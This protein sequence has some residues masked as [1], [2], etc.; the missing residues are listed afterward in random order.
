MDTL[1]AI[2][3]NR[4]NEEALIGAVLIAPYDVY[5]ATSGIVSANDFYIHRHQWI[6]EA[7]TNLINCG[8]GVDLLTVSDELERM[9]KLAEI[10]GPAY[11]IA[12]VNQVPTILNAADYAAEVL[13]MANRRRALGTA[14]NIAKAA[15]DISQPFETSQFAVE[16]SSTSST[17]NS[18]KR[19]TGIDVQGAIYDVIYNAIIPLTF[20]T[21]TLDNRLS[22]MFPEELTVLAGDQGSGKT[23]KA[24]YI[25][26]K[27]SEMGK[28]VVFV[29]LEMSAVTLWLRMACGDLGINI[30][31][32]RSNKVSAEVKASVLK[33]SQELA[34]QYSDRIIIYEAPM[35]LADIQA[36]SL[37][38]RPDLVIV[39]HVFLIAGPAIKANEQINNLN[40]ITRFLRMNVAKMPDHK[41]HVLLLWQLNRAASKDKRKPTKH[42][43]Y[44][45]GTNDPDSIIL[46]YREDMLANSA[47]PGV[48]VTLTAIAAKA[49]N[50]FTGEMEIKYDLQK[51][52]FFDIERR[53]R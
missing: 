16:L 1:P 22:G 48:P 31:Q 38:E 3:H 19:Y 36:A 29:S 33:R 28:R 10:G 40:A 15:Y 11:L 17:S 47:L 34:E 4:Q 5:L 32:V 27:N 18:S 7:I 14:N 13:D 41:C 37:V 24:I 42:D 26:R 52:T 8:R 6:W 43:L 20:G 21:Q 25:A 39:D 12:L 50:D 9:G 30:N 51:Q 49:R 2:P 45:A 35:T 44:M 53:N 46:L 23:A